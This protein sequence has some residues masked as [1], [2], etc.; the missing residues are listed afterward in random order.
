[1]DVCGGSCWGVLM[2]SVEKNSVDVFLRVSLSLSL[3]AFHPVDESI[4]GLPLKRRQ[5]HP[6]PW[7][8]KRKT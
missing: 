1:M 4:V 3:S 7:F 6:I 2:M 8:Y 5:G